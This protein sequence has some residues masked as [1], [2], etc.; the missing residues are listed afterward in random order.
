MNNEYKKSAYK[1][2]LDEE[3]KE[4]D[5]PSEDFIEEKKIYF[6]INLKKLDHF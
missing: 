3:T 5:K 1:H 2:L 6:L 4:D